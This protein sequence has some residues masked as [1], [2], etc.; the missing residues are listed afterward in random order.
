MDS[1]K[2][3]FETVNKEGKMLKLAIVKPTNRVVQEANM[4]YN[5][6]IADLMRKGASSPSGR[7]MS[8]SEL[9][10]YLLQMGL[11]TL[12]D[13]IEVEKL[14]M[15]IRA[16]ELRLKKGGIKLSEGRTIAL[17]M[18]EKRRLIMEKH[19]RRQQFDS[20]TLESQAENFRFEFL[21]V[22]CLVYVDTGKVFLADRHEYL[23]RQDEIAVIAGAKELA[24][25]LYGI[26]KNIH[27]HMFEM[28]W[29]KDAGMIDDDGRYTRQDGTITDRDG[30]LINKD[31]RYINSNGQLVDTFGRSVDE[32]GNL[33]V[34]TSEPFIDDTTGEAIVVGDIGKCKSKT[35]SKQVK[36]KTKTKT[37]AKTKKTKKVVVKK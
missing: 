19:A 30:R 7:L 10:K 9:E 3:V 27:N 34:E 13:S 25:M 28:R 37:K 12:E 8:R 31:G 6:K 15:E 4:A 11:W 2:C 1:K 21:L 18:A 35:K 5:L 22:K 29:L 17:E 16:Y 14:A 24:N 36:S 33:L 26:E 20:A 23:D 32:N